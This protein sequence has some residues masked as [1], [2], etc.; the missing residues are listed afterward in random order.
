MVR[1]YPAPVNGGGVA[2]RG[3]GGIATIGTVTRSTLSTD[4]LPSRVTPPH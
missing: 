3:G 1:V 4:Q 2:G